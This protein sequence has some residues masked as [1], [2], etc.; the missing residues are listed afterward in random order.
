MKSLVTGVAG[1]I[2]SHLAE[3]LIADG[4]EVVGVDCFTDYYPR[5]LKQENLAQLARSP[6]FRLVE[7]D[8][9]EGDLAPLLEGTDHVFH[10][11]G[12]AGVRSS[13]G[14]GF[15]AYVRDNVLATQR[16]LDAAR[17]R[18]SLGAF[19]FASSSSVYGDA[20]QSPTP[21]DAAPRPLSPYGVTKLA[22]EHLCRVY[23]E[24]FGVRVATLRYFT[25][26]GPRQRPDMAVRRFIT[27]LLDDQEIIVFGD[28]QQTRDFTY[29]GDVVQANIL[30]TA[31]AAAGEVFNIGG[32]STVS[33][34]RVLAILERITGRRA[35]VRYAGV[36]RGDSRHTSADITKAKVT[37][38]FTPLVPIEEGLRREIEWLA[39]TGGGPR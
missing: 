3:R 13:W 30:A 28:G 15:S 36:E 38:G 8:L 12:Q 35:R 33:I 5:A 32:G 19:V 39:G 7:A 14:R 24:S 17:G 31:S 22:C 20:E 1:F 16:L 27:A 9:G 4:H 10:L 2:G 34:N 11:A 18:A 6:A 26:Y 23:Y 37:L 29:V 25:A 21:E